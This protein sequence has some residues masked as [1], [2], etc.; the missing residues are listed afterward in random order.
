MDHFRILGTTLC[1]QP[2]HEVQ[3]HDVQCLSKQKTQPTSLTD[4][5]F[6][7]WGAEVKETLSSSTVM[8]AS[9]FQPHTHKPTSHSCY[10]V[11]KVFISICIGTQF[12]TDFNTVLFLIISRQTRHKFCTDV[13]HLK[14][15]SKNLMARYY[16]DAHIISNFSDS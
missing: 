4:S 5:S 12:L 6:F 2:D 15:F 11:L 1:L 7:L 3:I 9:W 14:F 10:D 8:I 16:A 13:M